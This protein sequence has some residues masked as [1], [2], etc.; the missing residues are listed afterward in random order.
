MAVIVLV[1]VV[2][3]AVVAEEYIDQGLAVAEHIVEAVAAVGTVVVA[4]VVEHS[5]YLA[6][7][8]PG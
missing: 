5:D 8:A 4:G 6:L 7:L 2:E 3:I 1:L